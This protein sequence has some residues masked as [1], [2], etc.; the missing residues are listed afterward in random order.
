[1][2]TTNEEAP[3]TYDLAVM[4][5]GAF[6][7]FKLFSTSKCITPFPGLQVKNNAE[8]FAEILIFL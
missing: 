6:F 1:M 7:V 5:C 4:V 2:N 8:F 3:Q